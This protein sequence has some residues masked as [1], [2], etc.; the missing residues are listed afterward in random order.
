MDRFFCNDTY[1]SAKLING[2]F[3]FCYQ[4]QKLKIVNDS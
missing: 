4:A 1:L 3:L 2:N